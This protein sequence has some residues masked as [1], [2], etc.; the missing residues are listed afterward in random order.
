MLDASFRQVGDGLGLG[1][2][3]LRRGSGLGV[4]V[5]GGLRLLEW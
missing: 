3:F 1:G 4:V 2:G 5:G